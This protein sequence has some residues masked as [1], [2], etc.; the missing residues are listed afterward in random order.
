MVPDLHKDPRGLFLEC[1]HKQEAESLLGRPL[2]F[3][4][5]NLSVSDKFVL[6]GLHFQKSPYE[7][8]KWVTVIQG[9]VLDVVVDLRPDSPTFGKHFKT[10]LNSESRHA[11]F[12]PEGMAHGFLSLEADTHLSYKC[13]AYYAPQHE[14]GIRFDDP[15]LAIDWGIPHHQIRLSEKD[16]GLPTFNNLSQ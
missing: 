14:A 2:N 7:Q 8:A 10:E 15:D 4:Q 1:F 12:V 5:D 13:S 9:R 6:R 16:Q 3:V 11:L